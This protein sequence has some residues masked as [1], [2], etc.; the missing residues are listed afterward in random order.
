MTRRIVRTVAEYEDL[1]ADTVLINCRGNIIQAVNIWPHRDLPATVLATGEQVRA[2]RK[3][4][5]DAA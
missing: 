5:G 2:A 3:A 1:H 4:L